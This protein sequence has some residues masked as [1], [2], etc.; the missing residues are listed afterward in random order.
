L[1]LAGDNLADF[2][3]NVLLTHEAFCEWNVD[4]TVLPTLTDVVTNILARCKIAGSSSWSPALS[5]PIAAM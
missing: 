4:F 2:A 3:G 5:A 1:F